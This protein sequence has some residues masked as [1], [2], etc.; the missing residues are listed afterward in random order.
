MCDVATQLNCENCEL[1]TDAVIPPC[2][3]WFALIQLL[4]DQILLFPI[5]L[6]LKCACLF[7]R[8]FPVMIL[9]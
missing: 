7:L 6:I 2:L 8:H 4:P 3:N 5:G 9:L 1:F